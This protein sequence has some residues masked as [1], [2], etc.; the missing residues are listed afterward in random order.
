MGDTLT[1]ALAQSAHSQSVLAGIQNPAVVNPLAGYSSAISAVSGMQGLADSDARQALGEAYQKAVDPATGRFDPLKFNQ[2]AAADPRTARAVK[3][4][5]ESSQTLQGQQLEQ[6]TATQGL[7]NGA[8]TAALASDDGNLKQ[9]V[10]EQAQRLRAAGIPGD[11]IDGALLHLSSDPAQLRQQLETLRVQSLPPDQKQQVIY[12][13][14]FRQTGPGGTTVGGVQ[15]VRRGGAVSGPPAGQAGLPQGQ[16]PEDLNAIVQIGTNPD[17]SARM[18]TKRQARNLAEGRD[19]NDDG[20][21]AAGG[22]GNASPLGTG[23]PIPPALQN[24][25]K[26]QAATQPAA[27]APGFTV[28]QGPATSSAQTATGTASANKFQDEAAVDTQAQ[29]QQAVLGNML[30]DTSQFTTGPLAG[31][32]GK[33]RNLAG[34]LGLNINAEAQ[35]SKE[36]FNKLAAGLANAQGAGSDARMNVNISANPHEE[37]S[38]AGV[39]LILRQLQGNSDYIR[40][41]SAL[42]AKYPN[43]ADYPGFQASIKD[44]D[45]RVFQ[46]TRMTG[47]QRTTYWKSLDD[48]TQKQLGAA[49]KK[50]KD[51]GV[52]G[53]G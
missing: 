10:L 8:V 45:P 27:P 29:N 28:G 17:G 43:K 2:L 52:L 34:N 20:P 18:G 6:N 42:A 37:L 24:P 32:V 14:P 44:L 16:S 48:Q 41:R 26:P 22:A 25:N 15:D 4:G 23:R 47:D 30:A 12:G 5:V 51:M 36:S 11:R 35:S 9:S 3:G 7:I 46:L 39:D 38:P 13:A 19:A 40:A 50:A 53:G 33:V 31:I 21:Y 1:N 49:I